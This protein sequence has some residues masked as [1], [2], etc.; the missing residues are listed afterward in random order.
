MPCKVG[1]AARAERRRGERMARDV[2][3]DGPEANGLAVAA[4]EIAVR[5]DPDEAGLAGDCFVHRPQVE[6]RVG[7][8]FV[9]RGLESPS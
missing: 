2:G 9:G 1:C 3:V 8:E 7:T 5:I 6:Q 4:H